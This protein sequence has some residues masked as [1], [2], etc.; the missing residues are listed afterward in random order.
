MK[1]LIPGGTRFLGRHLVTE[2]LARNHQ[3]TLFNWI[4]LSIRQLDDTI[5]GTLT[6]GQEIRLAGID[7]AKEQRLLRKWHE[8]H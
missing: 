6:S 8:A 2:A 3:I 4:C 7:P 1:L 5:K